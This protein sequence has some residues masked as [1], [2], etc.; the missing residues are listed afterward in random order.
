MMGTYEIDL[1]Y[2]YRTVKFTTEMAIA[3][4]AGRK[5]QTRRPLKPQP[6][7]KAFSVRTV[8]EADDRLCACFRDI[9]DRELF[10]HIYS[11]YQPGETLRVVLP[12]GAG[13]RPKENVIQRPTAVAVPLDAQAMEK[14]DLAANPLYIKV[15]DARC[16]ALQ[17]IDVRSC[18]LEGAN[19][20]VAWTADAK[21]SFIKLW[22]ELY[23][24][25]M[26]LRWASNPWV[27][28][29]ELERAEK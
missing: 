20:G 7:D 24:G 3:I 25:D 27:W 23:G 5:T 14:V 13:Q 8:S 15:T 4:A 28:V 29:Y 12:D 10:T 6:P 22:D 11:K 1:R 16:E 18:L 21:P 9:E 26:L 19:L 17:S 2:P